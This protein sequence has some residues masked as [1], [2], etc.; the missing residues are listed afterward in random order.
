MLLNRISIYVIYFLNN[1]FW[2]IYFAKQAKYF[3]YK[4]VKFYHNFFA[5][6]HNKGKIIIEEGCVFN[7]NIYLT[8]L[9]KLK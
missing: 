8:S 6:A 7:R 9:W 5:E 2:E 1:V 4:N 3:Y